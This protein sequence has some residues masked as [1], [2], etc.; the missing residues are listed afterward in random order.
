MSD[1]TP[2]I[3]THPQNGP[4]STQYLLSC[5]CCKTETI[6][7]YLCSNSR[8]DSITPEVDAFCCSVARNVNS[9]LFRKS[10][11]N[12]S[13]TWGAAW[14]SL[15]ISKNC[16]LK[17]EEKR[18]KQHSGKNPKSE[19]FRLHFSFS[20]QYFS[21]LRVIYHAP[22]LHLFNEKTQVPSLS[23]C[24]LVTLTSSQLVSYWF[25]DRIFNRMLSRLCLLWAD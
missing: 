3:S 5:Y 11:I 24:P 20:H 19:R 15:S 4:L 2:T 1:F 12:F 16:I 25:S 23:A 10:W 14:I 6:S 13:L 17:K 22:P 21:F 7:S 9:L 18:E 8:M